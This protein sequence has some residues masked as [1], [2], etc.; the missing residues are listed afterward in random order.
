MAKPVL[1]VV[2]DDD[3]SLQVLTGELES[4]YGAHY[5]VVPA[6][7]PQAGLTRLAELRTAGA[8]VPLVLADQRMQGMTGT[9]MLARV[10][11]IVPTARRGLL[12]PWGDRSTPAPYLEA[13]ALGWL[14]FYLPKP[15]WS[16]DE[17]FHRVVTGALEEWWR[18]QGGRFDS[19]TVIGSD[20]S[21]R[22]HEIRDLLARNSIPFGFYPSDSPQGLAALR[23]LGVQQPTGPVLSLYTGDVL[24][25]P[26]NAEVAA[27]LGLAVRPADP[28]Y[29]E[30]I[31]GAGPAGLAAAVYAASEGLSTALLEPEAFGGQA[32]TSSRIRNY[33][34][35]PSGIGGTELAQRAYEQ[36]WV[37]GT[38]LVYG[39]PVTRLT[40]DQDRLAVGLQDG[41]ETRA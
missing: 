25:D 8:D 33:L 34:G 2:D 23:Q 9:Q 32:G 19:V 16:P 10:K 31:V 11:D 30:V 38:H 40:R 27:G 20:R 37:F 15:T 36:A 39:N 22:V 21:P 4:R 35:F 7:S 13:A 41:S 17:Q 1:V 26:T 3:A 18:D 6:S 5:D 12:I 29:D 24:V 14:E 28:A